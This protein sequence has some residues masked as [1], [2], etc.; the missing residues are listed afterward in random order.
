MDD[1][2]T[3]FKNMDDLKDEAES[4][5]AVREGD[6]EELEKERDTLQTELAS[7]CTLLALLKKENEAL[8]KEN[9]GLK[10]D[11]Q[12]LQQELDAARSTKKQKTSEQSTHELPQ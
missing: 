3:E 8:E 4:E 5:A 12:E 2:Q 6:I 9:E 10:K 7:H 1:A 11:K